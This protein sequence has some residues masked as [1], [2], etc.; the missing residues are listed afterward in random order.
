MDHTVVAAI[1]QRLQGP[2]SAGLA[3]IRDYDLLSG[4]LR[5]LYRDRDY[6]P[7]WFDAGGL[8]SNAIEALDRLGRAEEH[9]LRPGDYLIGPIDPA[10]LGKF[11]TGSPAEAVALTELTISSMVVGV[12]W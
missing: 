3:D 8:T 4:H 7:M 1:E 10:L 12:G 11:Q 5:R 9:G 6:E 2:P